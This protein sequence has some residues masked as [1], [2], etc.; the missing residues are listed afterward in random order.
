MRRTK[1]SLGEP[2]VKRPLVQ[3][4]ATQMVIPPPVPQRNRKL[5]FDDLML[6][7]V[8]HNQQLRDLSMNLEPDAPWNNPDRKWWDDDT[9]YIDDSGNLKPIPL[10][11]VDTYSLRSPMRQQ[12][13][14]VNS[15]MKM[16]LEGLRNIRLNAD[17]SVRFG[18][19]D[20]IVNSK[21]KK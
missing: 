3:S 15:R 11:F 10:N 9:K 5:L 8:A 17:N 14:V 16:L 21:L 13:G 18:S 12:G 4:D 2:P 19:Y 6:N 20:N 1:F 7:N